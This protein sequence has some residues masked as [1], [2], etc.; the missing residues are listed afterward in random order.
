VVEKE[1]DRYKQQYNDAY[2]EAKKALDR[3]TQAEQRG[4]GDFFSPEN[5]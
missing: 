4:Q 1:R 2:D 5:A 3:A